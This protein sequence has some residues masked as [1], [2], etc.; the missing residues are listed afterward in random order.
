MKHK[1]HYFKAV[2]TFLLHEFSK[3]PHLTAEKNAGK[4]KLFLK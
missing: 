2:D 4:R 1:S 3:H